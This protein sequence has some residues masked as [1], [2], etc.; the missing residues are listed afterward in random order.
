MASRVNFVRTGVILLEIAWVV[1]ATVEQ[2][3]TVQRVSTQCAI[4]AILMYLKLYHLQFV[5]QPALVLHNMPTFTMEAVTAAIQVALHALEAL[6]QNAQPAAS[7]CFLQAM[8]L[9]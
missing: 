2:G 9:V 3:T 7:L 5:C 8:A 4:A 6:Q 1:S